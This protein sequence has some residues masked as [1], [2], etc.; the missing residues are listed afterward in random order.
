MENV[1]TPNN[2]TTLEQIVEFAQL[3]KKTFVDTTDHG[4]MVPIVVGKRDG[5]IW[6]IVFCPQVDKI[7]GLKAA[8]VLRAAFADEIIFLV[9]ARMAK[10]NIGET[11]EEFSARLPGSFKDLKDQGNTEIQDCICC[12]IVKDDGNS[13]MVGMTY[14][15]EG[16]NIIWGESE[17]KFE[18]VSGRLIDGLTDIMKT[19]LLAESPEGILLGQITG[20]EGLEARINACA[21][22]SFTQLSSMGYGVLVTGD[23]KHRWADHKWE[24][25]E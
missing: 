16:K 17:H 10:A 2:L 19:P 11:E 1:D 12:Q 14:S 25:N 22:A 15:L 21:H 8:H 5:E 13:H 3:Q 24:E 6:A 4:D 7:L 9:D 18:T 23:Q 20:I